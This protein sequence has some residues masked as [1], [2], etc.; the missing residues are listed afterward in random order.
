MTAALAQAGLP[1]DSA[2]RLCL[3]GRK[4][5]TTSSVSKLWSQWAEYAYTAGISSD[6]RGGPVAKH[7]TTMDVVE[8]L[9]TRRTRAGD[10]ISYGYFRSFKACTVNTLL[11]CGSLKDYDGTQAKAAMSHLAGSFRKRKPDKPRYN[12]WFDMDDVTGLLVEE[13]QTDPYETR[14]RKPMRCTLSILAKLTWLARSDD[15]SKVEMDDLL[16]APEDRKGPD[17]T[18]SHFGAI[19]PETGY[20]GSISLR[21]EVAKTDSPLLKIKANPAE[22]ALCFV[23]CAWLWRRDAI[24]MGSALQSTK[25]WFSITQQPVSSDGTSAYKSVSSD[26][27]ARDIKEYLGAAGIDTDIYKPHAVR[28]AAA[29]KMLTNGATIDAILRLGRWKSQS[30]FETYYKRTQQLCDLQPGTFLSKSA[31]DKGSKREAPSDTLSP[32]KPPKERS[33]PAVGK[34]GVNLC[35][36]I[37]EATPGGNADGFYCWACSKSPPARLIHCSQCNVHICIHH[38]GTSK[39]DH[40]LA[41]QEF[42]QIGWTC[43]ECPGSI[44]NPSSEGYKKQTWSTFNLEAPAPFEMKLKCMELYNKNGISRTQKNKVET[45]YKTLNPPSTS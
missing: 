7:I 10:E 29:S 39:Q 45:L 16:A 27:I 34:K 44:C 38:F 36:P 15:I 25:F 31:V 13:F 19:D 43:S 30:V 2:K 26:S 11:L 6:A 24:S 18:R 3:K 37:P 8:Y 32:Q 21:I 1:A 22:P 42:K 33:L 12:E 5:S 17:A 4:D 14:K 20:P 23:L 35:R 41:E 40:A 9:D 28:G